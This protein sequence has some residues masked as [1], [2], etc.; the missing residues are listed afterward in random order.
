MKEKSIKILLLLLL[1]AL[2]I[3]F[4]LR[5]AGEYY[6]Y[7]RSQEHYRLA[8][9]YIEQNKF[10]EA[11]GE[12]EKSIEIYPYNYIVYE[13]LISIYFLNRDYDKA[14]EVCHYGL[15]Y[16]PKHFKIYL[17]LSQIYVMKKDYCKA[18]KSV[19]TAIKLDGMSREFSG[20]G[21]IKAAHGRMKKH[22]CDM[23]K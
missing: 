4:G 15:K 6:S 18:L 23:V 17:N 14:V 7:S 16:M 21:T 2:L 13:E 10:N 11:I 3:V 9:E 8:D 19:E 1:A 5:A 12:L 22:N 20:Y